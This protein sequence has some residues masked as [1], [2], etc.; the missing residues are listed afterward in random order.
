MIAE[1]SAKATAKGPPVS[2][3]LSLPALEPWQWGVAAFCA[4]LVGFSKN[5]IG[6][7]GILVVPMFA[8]LFDA[9]A[10][11]GVLLPILCLGDLTAV[12]NYRRHVQWRYV[13][14]PMPWAV[15]GVLVGVVV[16]ERIDGETFR[17]LLGAL[18]IAMV[19]LMLYTERV[20]RKDAPVPTAWWFSALVG[21]SGGFAT[22]VAN[23]AGP[24]WMF[25]LLSMQLPRYRFLGTGAW[26][27][28]IL[29]LF[30]VPFHIF[31]WETITLET[32][33]FDLCLIPAIVLGAWLGVLLVRRIDEKI[34]RILIQA[35]AAIA[36]GKLILG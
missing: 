21:V 18:V 4:L 17:T 10:S 30:K 32:F 1:S 2:S 25:Y 26:F 14:K 13:L 33:L 3:H 6:G 24:L 11:T 12:R 35:S 29:N 7:A 28:L 16:G 23:A 36:A 15:A 27:F 19:A 34:F 8:A 20:R 22:M 9:Q 5:G 31:V